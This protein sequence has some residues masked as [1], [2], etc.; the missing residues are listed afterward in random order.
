MSQ[1]SRKILR[2]VSGGSRSRK[3][4]HRAPNFLFE[5]SLHLFAAKETNKDHDYTDTHCGFEKSK[6]NLQPNKFTTR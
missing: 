3:Q 2:V 6:M 5:D 4:L 1:L